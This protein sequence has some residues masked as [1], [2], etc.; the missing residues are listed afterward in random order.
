[1]TSEESWQTLEV[2]KDH[3][4]IFVGA[5]QQARTN[6][7]DEVPGNEPHDHNSAFATCLSLPDASGYL[8]DL[9]SRLLALAAE[10]VRADLRT[11][12]PPR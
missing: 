6:R 7:P 9:L 12:Q 2:E 11:S 4:A 1:M 10:E 5:L 8:P 3:R